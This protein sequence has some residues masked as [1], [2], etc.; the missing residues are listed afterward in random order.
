MQGTL[1][2]L[3]EYAVV[4]GLAYTL[5]RDDREFNNM[6]ERMKQELWVSLTIL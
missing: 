2:R 1:P 6:A 4:T 3:V 5:D